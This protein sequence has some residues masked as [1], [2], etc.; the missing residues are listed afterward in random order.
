MKIYTKY[1]DKGN[2][3]LLGG[4]STTKDDWRI[5]ACGGLDEFSATL[6]IVSSYLA[7]P[8]NIH[9]KKQ[10]ESIQSNLLSIGAN[11]AALGS[12]AK[13]Q[14]PSLKESEVEVVEKHIDEM[15]SQLPELKN[16]I[17]PGGCPPAA[18]MHFARTVC[19][20]AESCLVGM[21]PHFGDLDETNLATSL[22]YLNRLS[23]WCFVVARFLNHSAG[24][25][26]P[27]WTT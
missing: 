24:F 25:D 6:G 14:L 1:G 27:I 17:L 3:Q 11:V 12:D 20:R 9:L 2:T 21:I 13:M 5:R 15:Q 16:F 19:R 22:K 18:Q 23:D 10:I 8:T 26:E 4:Q 7:D